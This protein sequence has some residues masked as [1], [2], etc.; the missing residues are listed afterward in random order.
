MKEGNEITNRKE[1]QGTR[2]ESKKMTGG[3]NKLDLIN[4]DTTNLKKK[5]LKRKRD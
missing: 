1:R 4:E 5:T 3:H 2:K